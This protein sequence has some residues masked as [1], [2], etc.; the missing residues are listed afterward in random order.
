MLAVSHLTKTFNL[1]TLFEDIT[2]SINPEE[3]VGLIGPN[4]CGKTTLLRILVGQEQPDVGQVTHPA[5]LR[6]G[7]LP[8]QF[9]IP[10]TSTLGDILQE[11]AGNMDALA[12]DLVKITRALADQPADQNLQTQY[13]QILRRM[14]MAEPQ[15][16]ESMAAGLGLD[17]IPRDLQV[18]K[19]SGGQQTRLSLLLVL[20]QEPQIL[21]LD[22]PTNHLDIAML[23]WLESWLQQT[24][25]GALI[26]SHDR[27]FLD[28]TVTRILEIDPLPHQMRSYVGNYTSYL[29]QRRSEIEAQWTAYND[30]EAEVRRMKADIARVKAQAAYTERQ[31]SSIRIGGPDM[32]LKGFKSYQQGI[33]KKVARKAKAR[34]KR[35]ERY[36]DS[37]ERVEKPRSQRMIR[38]EF[39][40]APHLGRSVI[41]MERLGVGFAGYPALIEEINLQVRASQRIAFTGPNGSGKTTL[42]RTLAG[43]IPPLAGKIKLGSSVKLGVMSQ[44]IRL[45]DETQ[46]ALDHVYRF[47]PNQTEA[48]RFLGYYLLSGDEVL[49][50]VGQLSLGQRAR[51]Q[52]ALLVVDGCNVLL[53]DEPLNHLDISS[54][55]QFEQALQSFKGAILMVVHD[56]YFIQRFAQEVWQVKGK[57]IIQGG[58][59]LSDKK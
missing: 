9:A 12:A 20:L 6:I 28:R 45:L 22:E 33:A 19:L 34:E 8:Q 35:L 56:R 44:D 41:Q 58:N 4:G 23:E 51:L 29:E 40:Q 54:R 50:P 46:S 59:A 52:L 30:Q 42:L 43:Q 53:L 14:E 48:R 21:L 3:R 36:K 47:F 15:R 37:D 18:G 2:F 27:T 10:A 55:T 57:K 25:C 7:Y 13:D 26:V 17:G 32:K 5:T 49:K 39:D 16:V 24:S 38:V 1:K 31:A 11:A